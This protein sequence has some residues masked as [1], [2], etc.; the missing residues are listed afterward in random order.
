MAE[1]VDEGISGS[2]SKRPGLTQI[3]ELA[4]KGRI[5]RL[6]IWRLDRLF[7]SLKHLINT[8]EE[9]ASVNVGLVSYSENIDL[10]TPQG[11]LILSV[12]G[13]IGEFEKTLITERVLAGLRR[14]RTEGIVLGRPKVECDVSGIQ[15]L[16]KQ[17]L[18]LRK[19]GA[20]MGVSKD[21]VSRALAQV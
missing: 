3:L 11:R 17:G 8:T 19:I 21:V 12:L 14:A 18:S 13:A 1:C 16:S 4:K 15:A 7:R 6:V 5:D 10:S 9:L 20:Q 2:E